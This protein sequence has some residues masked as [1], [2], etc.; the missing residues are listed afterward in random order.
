[1]APLSIPEMAPQ[2]AT[3]VLTP[4]LKIILAWEPPA[5][6]AMQVV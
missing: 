3:R 4:A 6:D 5:N 2:P 1:M